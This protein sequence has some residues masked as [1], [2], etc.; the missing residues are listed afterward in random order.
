MFFTSNVLLVVV[1]IMSC[2][3]FPFIRYTRRARIWVV[4]AMKTLLKWFFF[5]PTLILI[6]VIVVVVEEKVEKF[7]YHYTHTW[8]YFHDVTWCITWCQSNFYLSYFF[9]ILRYICGK[10]CHQQKKSFIV[11]LPR[12]IRLFLSQRQIFI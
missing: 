8:I 7:H 3:I 9:N 11:R 10:T 2:Q 12:H 6:I 5:V 1:Y 4:D